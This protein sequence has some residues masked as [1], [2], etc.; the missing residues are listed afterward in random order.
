MRIVAKEETGD[1][2]DVVREPR[3]AGAALALQMDH[4]YVKVTADYDAG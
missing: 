4:S 3:V 1:D 2:L